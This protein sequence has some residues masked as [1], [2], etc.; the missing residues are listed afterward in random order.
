VKIQTKKVNSAVLPAVTE[1]LVGDQNLTMSISREANP[2]EREHLFRRIREWTKVKASQWELSRQEEALT[3]IVRDRR[4]EIVAG[5]FGDAFLGHYFIKIVWIEEPYQKQ[6]LGSQLMRL[7][8]DELR[9]LGCITAS[10]DTMDFQAQGFYEKLGYEKFAE[11][12]F[13]PGGP[14]KIFMK[15]KL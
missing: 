1:F 15:K 5:T 9:K 12:K 8:E 3:I 13:F 14:A 4:G 7:Q 10:L 2:P 6:G 11:L